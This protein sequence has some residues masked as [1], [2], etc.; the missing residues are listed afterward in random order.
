M[1]IKKGKRKICLAII[2]AMTLLLGS[3]VYA[4]DI[5]AVDGSELLN[6]EES[7]GIAPAGIY[8]QTGYSNISKLGTGLIA[9]GGTTTAATTVSTV[10]VAVIVERLVGGNWIQYT[11]WS[12]TKY[13]AD[14]VMSSKHVTVP[15]GF[16]YRTRCIH[17]A[18]TDASSSQTNGLYV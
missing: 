5:E 13:N 18:N 6:S 14:Y 15:T 9:A 11:S 8:L 4:A 2:L 10:K 3:T 16:Y 12:S 7:S 1:I 17:S